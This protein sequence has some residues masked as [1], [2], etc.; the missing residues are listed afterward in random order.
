MRGIISLLFIVA[1]TSVIGACA[2]RV[3]SASSSTGEDKSGSQPFHIMGTSTSVID[4]LKDSSTGCEYLIVND[5]GIAPRMFI[6]H[7]G[8][9][10]QLGCYEEEPEK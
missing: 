8:R 5:K 4:V 7:D 6:G 3:P 2:A 9:Y 10:T 1:T